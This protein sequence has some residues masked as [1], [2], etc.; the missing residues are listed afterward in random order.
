MVVASDMDPQPGISEGFDFPALGGAVLLSA[1]GL[2]RRVS[3]RSSSRRSRS[4]QSC[5]RAMWTGTTTPAAGSPIM[6][7]TS[8]PS[9]SPTPTPPARSSAPSQPSASSS[10]PSSS[11]S[12]RSSCSSPTP[13]SPGSPRRL[14]TRLG[15]PAERVAAPTNG[16][17]VAH[18]AAPAF[19]LESGRLADAAHDAVRLRGRRDHSRRRDLPGVIQREP[20]ASLTRGRRQAA[21]A[22]P[23]H[24]Q[25][26]RPGSLPPA[27]ESCGRWRGSSPKS[28]DGSATAGPRTSSPRSGGTRACSA[29][30]CATRR[31]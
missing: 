5:S 30:G 29:P 21:S 26:R 13:R 20:P 10:G 24:A 4:S 18:T 19:A 8:S 25:R 27:H 6:A 9:R 14:A 11:T 28:R 3:P 7:G 22:A 2:A 17:A 12:A 15:V 1:D 16:V 31:S 23:A